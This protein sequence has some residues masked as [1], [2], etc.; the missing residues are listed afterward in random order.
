MSSGQYSALSGA[1]SRLKL[2]DSISDNL[3][4]NKTVGFKKSQVAFEARLA[5][6][7]NLHSN[8][9][10]SLTKAKEGFTDYGQGPLIRTGVPTHMAIDGEGFFK[11]QQDE[12]TVYYTRQGNFHL[13]DLGHM[14]NGGGLKVLGEDGKPIILDN[15]DVLVDEDGNIMLEGGEV[16]KLPLY[17]FDDPTVMKREG[18]GL[19]TVSKEDIEDFE[20]RVEEPTIIQGQI[21]D[22]NVNMMQEMGKMI[23]SLRVF[24]SYQK[25]IR[26]ADDMNAK[27][28]NEVGKVA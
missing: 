18:G 17:K 1:L 23:E 6:A 2:M 8:A 3:A 28:V 25:A 16:K 20:K 4:N 13:D 22:S 11:V 27:A 24:E 21:E 10:L 26:T 12:N 7:Q 15:P 9:A 5:E 14:I 19:F